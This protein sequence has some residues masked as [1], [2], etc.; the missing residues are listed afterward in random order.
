MILLWAV[1]L[2]ILNLGWLFVTALGLPGN[3]LMVLSTALVAWWQW[4]TGMFGP[5]VLVAVVALALTG[6]LMELLGGIVGARRGGGTRWGALGA[7]VGGVFG[8]LV[9][10]AVAPVLGTLLGVCLGAFVGSTT[11]EMAAGRGLRPA[12]RAGQGA[13]VGQGLG[14]LAKL[15]V[16]VVIWLTVAVAAFWP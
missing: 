3:W 14:V 11:L 16:G 15:A 5:A 12:L 2:C 13:G 9:G 10:T 1:T 7:I 6:E 8:G 4:E